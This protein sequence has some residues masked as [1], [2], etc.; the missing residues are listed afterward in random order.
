M[1]TPTWGEVR[2]FLRIDGWEPDR[3]TGH[4]FFV[5]V[6]LDGSELRT[7]VSFADDKTMSAGRFASI[8]RTQLRITTDAFW[9][10]LR[11]QRPVPRP[12]PVQPAPTNAI[13]AWAARVLVH[14]LH[15]TN[16]EVAALTV[17]EAT[18]RVRRF[19]TEGGTR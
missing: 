16:T 8:C 13:P 9:E 1:K 14:D 3:T 4:D 17:E 2:E 7:H 12:S 6:L 5:K 15:L 19:W 18:A 11:L 10:A